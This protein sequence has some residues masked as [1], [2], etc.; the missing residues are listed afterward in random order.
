MNKIY[1]VLT[2]STLASI[3]ISCLIFVPCNA[4]V[5][6]DKTL[7]QNTAIRLDKNTTIIEGGSQVGSNLFHSFLE[8]SVIKDSTAF[9]NNT[10]NI[11]NIIARVTGDSISN[12]DGLIRAN[13][14]A[15]LFFINPNGIIFGQNARLNIGGTF[16]GSTASSINFANGFKFSAKNPQPKPLLTISVPIGLEFQGIPATIEVKGT[17]GATRFSEL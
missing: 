4:Q 3:F 11:Q 8:F 1:L 16:V 10:N 2:R 13:G 12:I 15:N 9:F 7:R 17:G 14:N 6:P 5:I